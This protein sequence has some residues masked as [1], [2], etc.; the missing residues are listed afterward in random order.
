MLD[1][2]SRILDQCVAALFLLIKRIEYLDPVS[3]IQY[4]ASLRVIHHHYELSVKSCP[5]R[6]EILTIAID[7]PLVQRLIQHWPIKLGR[8]TVYNL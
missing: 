6:N 5:K 3:S 4:L 8:S 1:V 2:G 7:Y